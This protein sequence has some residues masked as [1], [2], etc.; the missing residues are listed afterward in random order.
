[1]RDN[2]SSGALTETT[3][4]VLLALHEKMHGYGVKIWIEEKTN[5]DVSLG[6]GTLYGTINNLLKKQWIKEHS[7]DK[8]RVFYIITDRGKEIVFEENKRLNNLINLVHSVS[9]G[10]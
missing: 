8:R 9:G 4:L 1:M 5:G 6:M 3:L 7:K 10:K 2:L